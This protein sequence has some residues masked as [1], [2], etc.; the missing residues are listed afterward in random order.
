MDIPHQNL[1]RQN[2]LEARVQRL[3]EAAGFADHSQTQLHE[4][5]LLLMNE[6]RA[7]QKKLTAIERRLDEAADDSAD[8]KVDDP[9][10]DS[11][12]Q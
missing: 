6:L 11:G 2:A 10:N 12:Q 4:Q 1:E 7:T 5:V 8:A 9:D 3:E